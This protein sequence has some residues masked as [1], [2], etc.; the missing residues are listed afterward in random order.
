MDIQND[1]SFVL[2]RG[3][4]NGVSFVNPPLGG[5]WTLEHIAF[6]IRE[7]EKRPRVVISIQDIRQADSSFICEAYTD[8][9]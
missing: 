1:A 3:G 2:S 6:A 8:R 5:T 7:I 4:E 9:Q